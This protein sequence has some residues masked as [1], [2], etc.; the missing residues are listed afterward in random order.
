MAAWTFNGKALDDMDRDELLHVAKAL[1]Q[2]LETER[3]AKTQATR[4]RPMT[5]FEIEYAASEMGMR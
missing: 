5:R 4:V 2:R 3:A 1:V